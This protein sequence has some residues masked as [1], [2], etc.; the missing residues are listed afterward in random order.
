MKGW[1]CTH[2]IQEDLWKQTS[3]GEGVNAIQHNVQKT[4]MIF[5]VTG[6]LDLKKTRCSPPH[7]VG[8]A[9]GAEGP[10]EDSGSRSNNELQKM[11]Q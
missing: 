7:D 8:A 4:E 10:E 6:I 9:D 11:R 5:Q 2:L 1:R 3:R